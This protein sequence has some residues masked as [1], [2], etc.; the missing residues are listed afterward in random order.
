MSKSFGIGPK[1][2]SGAA[3]FS[4]GMGG[5]RRP[6]WPAMGGGGPGG[7]PGGGLGPSGLSGS[8]GPPGLEQ[9]LKSR[10]SLNFSAMARNVLNNV[11]L[12]SSG[13]RASIAALWQIECAGRRILLARLPPTAASICR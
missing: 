12:A 1:V 11:N 7:G 4:G 9:N 10:Y 2:T 5:R 6:W 3:G 8:G 13:E